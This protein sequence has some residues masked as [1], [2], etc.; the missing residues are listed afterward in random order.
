MGQHQIGFIKGRNI[1]EWVIVLHD[2]IHE[3]KS[4]RTQGVILKIDFEKTYNI[5]R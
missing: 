4:S 3:L 1:L 2:V 5:V